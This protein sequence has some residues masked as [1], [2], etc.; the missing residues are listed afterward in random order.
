MLSAPAGSATLVPFHYTTPTCRSLKIERTIRGQ[1][2]A[3]LGS[4]WRSSIVCAD[5]AS[6]LV[7][8]WLRLSFEFR[9]KSS[10]DREKAALLH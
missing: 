3:G 8:V 6:I 5:G 1:A 2:R 10:H 9:F 4:G 7:A